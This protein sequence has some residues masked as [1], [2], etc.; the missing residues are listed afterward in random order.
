MLTRIS[1]FK[2]Y[3]DSTFILVVVYVDDCIVLSQHLHLIYE[4]KRTLGKE[5][6][7]IYVFI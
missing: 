3:K 7:M 4:L 5:F 1:K 2:T 6:E